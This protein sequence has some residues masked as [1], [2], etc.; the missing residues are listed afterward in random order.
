MELSQI[1]DNIYPMPEASK[2]HLLQL[3]RRVHYPK[4]HLLLRAGKIETS[5]YFISKGIVRAYAPVN[6]QDLTFWFGKEGQTVV[7]MRSY[8]EHKAGYENIETL[9]DCELFELNTIELGRLFHKD[10]E[11]ANW[12]RIFAERELIQTEERLISQQ[13]HSAT[14]RYRALMEDHPDL[15]Q[16]VQ[17]GYIA[18]YLGITQVSLSRIRAEFK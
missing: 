5:L 15:L 2:L 18:S 17:L 1:L 12:G 10:I 7:S 8:V 6:G 11:I 16:R 3:A 13:F 9:E 4:G 14:E